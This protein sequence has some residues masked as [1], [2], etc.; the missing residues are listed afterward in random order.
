MNDTVHHIVKYAFKTSPDSPVV[1]YTRHGVMEAETNPDGYNWVKAEDYKTEINKL[2]DYIKQA[3]RGEI[4]LQ[5]L[6]NYTV[7]L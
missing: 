1:L 6:N 5:Q 2:Q 3:I 4:S 7:K